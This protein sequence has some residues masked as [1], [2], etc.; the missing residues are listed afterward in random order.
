MDKDLRINSLPFASSRRTFVAGTTAVAGA[1]AVGL[2]SP[3]LFGQ[4]TRTRMDIVTFARDAARLAKFE[5]AVKEMQ[6]RS[7][8][9]ANDPKGW[10]VNANAHNDFCAVPSESDPAQIHF[11]WWFIA[12]HRAY[13][14]I[15]ERKIRE[16]SGDDTFSYPYW[17]WSSDRRIPAAY[18][19][20]GSSLAKAV[21]FPRAQPPGL[22]DGEVGY[23][24]SDPVLKALGVQALGSTFFEAT[25]PDDIPFSFGGIA[26]P[27]QSNQ[28]D[29][30]ALEDTPH[31]PVH[32]YV[33]GQ[34]RVNGR[35][36]PG[37]MT[38]FTTAARDPIFFAHHGNLDR[39]WETWRRDPARKATEPKSDAFL[40]HKFVFTWLDGAP[41]E[42]PMSDILDIAKLGYTYDY[43]DVFRPNEPLVVA[44]QAAPESLPPIAAQKLSVPFAA[45]SAN[46]NERKYLEISGVQNPSEPMSVS[47]LVKPANALAGDRG[48]EIG[49]FAVVPPNDRSAP[50]SRRLVFDMTDAARRYGGQDVTV[51]LVPHRVG[52]D[53]DQSFPPLKYE[54]MQILTRG[55]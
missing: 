53:A 12:W 48:T 3:S 20:A 11:C 29:N 55:R 46:A 44:S 37:D 49:T 8:A 25:S 7:A 6:D 5:A 27:N 41:V 50:R 43:L 33:G 30:N 17:N 32:V 9:N 31:G 35:Q 36:V 42:V 51:E 15:T 45:Q 10:L 40:Q 26:R 2:A 38:I 28:Y 39:L 23:N 14:S 13:I 1:A 21:R 24:Q 52:P 47:V 19:K 54:R 18:A 22:T 16:I 4:T 34:K